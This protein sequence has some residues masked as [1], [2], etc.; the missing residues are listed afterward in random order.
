MYSIFGYG[1][2]H[3]YAD[4]YADLNEINTK[5]LAMGSTV[6]VIED[7]IKYILNSKKQWIAVQGGNSDPS[8]P[9][10]VIYDGGRA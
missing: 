2:K 4:T 9:S 5:E 7:S 3:Y 6:Y 8:M 10:A 1:V